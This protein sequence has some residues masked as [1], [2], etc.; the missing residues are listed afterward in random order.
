M[1]FLNFL[2]STKQK[3][4]HDVR[5]WQKLPFL[6]FDDNMAE[7]ARRQRA[8]RSNISSKSNI[9][10]LQHL[11]AV[12]DFILFPRSSA[13]F[14][15]TSLMPLLRQTDRSQRN[16]NPYGTSFIFLRKCKLCYSS[17]FSCLA[18]FLAMV[19]ENWATIMT[20][21]NARIAIPR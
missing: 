4:A 3:I 1:L 7:Q 19:F 18:L 10:G 16:V 5:L 2:R 6:S 15:P 12:V 20:E 14:S 9:A 11:S 21:S 8:K 13:G 17:N